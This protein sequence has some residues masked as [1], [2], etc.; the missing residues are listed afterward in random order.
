MILLS[1]RHW[2]ALIRVPSGVLVR[3]ARPDGGG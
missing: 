1:S 2:C 3:L